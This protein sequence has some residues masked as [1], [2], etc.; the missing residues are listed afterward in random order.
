MS[1][2][3]LVSLNNRAFILA[4]L[5]GVDSGGGGGGGP[6]LQLRLDGRSPGDRRTL[7]IKAGVRATAASAAVA[8]KGPAGVGRGGDNSGIVE[9][10]LGQTRSEAPHS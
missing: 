2:D 9:V 1:R 8:G 3:V 7:S 4:A 6:R 5:R 10:A